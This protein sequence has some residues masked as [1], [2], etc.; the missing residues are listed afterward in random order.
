MKDIPRVGS[1]WLHLKTGT[2]YIVLDTPNDRTQRENFPTTVVYKDAQ[3]ANSAHYAKT[4]ER[5][6]ETM[7]ELKEKKSV[8]K[9]LSGGVIYT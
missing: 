7:V 2:T 9:E 8:D 6:Q 3:Y 5:F 4:L 1:L